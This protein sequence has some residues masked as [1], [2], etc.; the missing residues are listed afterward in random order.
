MKYISLIFLFGFFGVNTV[1]AQSCFY[2]NLSDLYTNTCEEVAKLTID[3][4]SKLQAASI[5]GA[6]YKISVPCDKKFNTYLKKKCYAVEQDGSFYINCR[7][8]KYKRFRFGYGYAPAYWIDGFIYF[9]AIPV[10]SVAANSTTSMNVKLGGT[11]GDA[12]AASG[13]TSQRVFYMINPETRK[14]EFVGKQKIWSLLEGNR[15]LQDQLL[16]EENESADT[17]EPYLLA[18]KDL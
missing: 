2:A 15:E 1:I 5:M 11:V 10:G 7:R 9:K 13:L 14:A 17:L 6:D 16:Q 18:V 4:R 12:F 3:K 8:L